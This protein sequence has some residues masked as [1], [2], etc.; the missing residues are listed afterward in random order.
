MYDRDTVCALQRFLDANKVDGDHGRFT[1]ASLAAFLNC[2]APKG[3]KHVP[4]GPIFGPNYT[5]KPI[6]LKLQQF[7][8]AFPALSESITNNRDLVRHYNASMAAVDASVGSGSLA[9]RDEC[10]DRVYI[11]E[12]GVWCAQ[13]TRGLQN[14]LNK[15]HRGADFDEAVAAVAMLPA[16]RMQHLGDARERTS[17]SACTIA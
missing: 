11:R 14:V 12:T 5:N 13:T 10:L 2:H 16:E 8:N 17:G 4:M 6:V 7:L 9:A 15:V 1:D 3:A